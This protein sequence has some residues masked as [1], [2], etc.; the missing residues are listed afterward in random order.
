[1]LHR[2]LVA[3]LT[4]LTFLLFSV[5]RRH[6]T[7]PPFTITSNMPRNFKVAIV[8]G[9]IVGLICA[10]GLAKAG[11]EVDVFEA[12]VSAAIC[13]Y[14]AFCRLLRYDSINM[15][16]LVLGSAS[17]CSSPPHADKTLI[18]Q[19]FRTECGQEPRTD[20]YT[21]GNRRTLR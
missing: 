8:G 6:H 16:I 19:M 1:M 10:I 13:S 12:A 4:V 9:G 7:R 15:A 11:V 3:G 20:G 18:P 14:S 17:V 21:G 5:T 2:A